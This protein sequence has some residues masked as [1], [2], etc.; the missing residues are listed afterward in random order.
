MSNTITIL[1][2]LTLTSM[3]TACVIGDELVDADSD[4]NGDDGE[5]LQSDTAVDPRHV[6]IGFQGDATQFD[7]WPDWNQ[8]TVV[9]PG[10]KVCHY[11][12]AWNVGN[13]QPHSGSIADESSRAY[14]DSW[15]ARAQGTCSEVL[16]A[17]KSMT[18]RAAVDEDTFTNA[19][20]NF[21]STD[22]KAETGY[23]GAF[24]FSTWNEPNNPGDA[25]NGLGVKIEANLAARYYLAA[26][27][28]C[29]AHGCRVVAGD[30]ASNGD[31]WDDFEWNC[32]N[33]NVEASQL[34]NTYSS[35]NTQH[36]PA[37]YLDKYKNEIARHASDR[38]YNLGAHFRPA[39]FAYHGWHDTNEYIYAHHRCTSYGDCAIRRIL[40]SLGGSWGAVKIWD[41]EDGM[42]QKG[43][44]TDHDQACGAAF[45]MRTATISPRTDRVFVTRLHGGD[46]QLEIGHVARA[47]FGV[48]AARK[49]SYDGTCL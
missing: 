2:T 7:Y 41:T 3:L 43:A 8:A 33:D 20:K 23:T 37:S 18:P 17:F 22:W 6:N 47:A 28:L 9:Q 30:F 29:K 49:T 46:L 42:G 25:G 26:E 48:L 40:T 11:Y 19:F 5:G 45:V 12:F 4:G 15:L 21:V 34:C 27:K 31:M 39:V 38:K 35:V 13:Q 1:S 44:L 16:I 14:L 10:N 24:T 36:H 32:A